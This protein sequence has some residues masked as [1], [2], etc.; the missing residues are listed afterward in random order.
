MSRKYYDYKG[1]FQAVMT[2]REAARI[3]GVRER[4]S[5]GERE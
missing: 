3:L 5:T 2:R 4:I 1:G